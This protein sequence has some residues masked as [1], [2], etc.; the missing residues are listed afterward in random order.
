[1]DVRR[2]IERAVTASA[3]KVWPVL[4]RLGNVGPEPKPFQPRWSD[5]PIPRG[6]E[7]T[8]PPLG[9]PRETDS[10]CPTCVKEARATILRGDADWT[11]L[12]TGKP[13]EIRA[14]IVERDGAIVMEKTCPVH[15]SFSDTISIDTEFLERIEGL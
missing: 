4:T 10:L 3:N 7:K 13:G 12:L 14:K 8:K 1:M 5:S 15:G 11:T 9:W 2:A 6:K